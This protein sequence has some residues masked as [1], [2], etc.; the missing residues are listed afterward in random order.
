MDKGPA[1][2]LGEWTAVGPPRDR[3]KPVLFSFKLGEEKNGQTIPDAHGSRRLAN[4]RRRL[5]LNNAGDPKSL[6]INTPTDV[7]DR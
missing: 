3:R 2:A 4:G 7:R 5:I 6:R 1:A